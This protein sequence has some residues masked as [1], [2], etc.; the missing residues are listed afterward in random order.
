MTDPFV[1]QLTFI[2]VYSGVMTV[3]LDGLQRD[4]AEDRA[5]RPPAEDAREQ[6]RGNQGSLRRRHRRRGRPQDASR[7]GDTICDEKNAGRARVDGLPR[8]GHLARD[9]AE[10]Q[11]RP[12]K[13][14]HRPQQADG[15]G[16]D[17]PRQDRPGDRRS[18]HRRHGRAAPRDHRRPPEARVQRRGERRPS[19][20]RLQGN[21]DPSR[22]RRD[23]VRRSRPAAA[24]STATRRST[25]SPASR[26]RATSSRTRSPAARSRRSS[27]SRSTKA[28]RKRSR[29][30]CSPAT[31]STTSASS[32]TTARTTT[33]T[34]RKWRSRSPAR[35][36]SR[37]RRR[38]PSRCCSS[39]SCA[40]K[41]WCRRSTWA[42]SWATCRAAAAHIQSQEDRGGTQIINARVPLSEMFGYATDLRS[43]TQGRATYSM[44]FD[45]YEPAPNHVS[46]EVVARM[47]GKA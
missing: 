3:G 2:R 45:R 4:Q 23:E 35:W 32:S 33:S 6:A 39:R 18:R 17:L 16:P 30:A 19:A 20:G 13:A 34:R 29:A 44:H 40:S 41:S 47:Q 7:T 37:T 46:E 31:R 42:T 21:A 38:R 11:G 22:R 15:G 27:S 43:R 8:A 5:P 1:G 14:R 25:C 28:S 10:D 12:G 26:A 24:V 9:R 36:R